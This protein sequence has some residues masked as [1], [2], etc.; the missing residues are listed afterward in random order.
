MFTISIR[1]LFVGRHVHLDLHNT[2]S[3]SMMATQ[4][5]PKVWITLMY[6]FKNISLCSCFSSKYTKSWND[7][8]I[9]T[10]ELGNK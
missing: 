2:M 9:T 3:P 10:P 4:G 7:M 6:Q 1:L 5:I 8:V